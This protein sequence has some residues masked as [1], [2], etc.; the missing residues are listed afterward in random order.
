MSLETTII[1]IDPDSDR[2]GVAIYRRGKLKE[3]A[4]MTTIQ[5]LEAV[6]KEEDCLLSIENTLHSGGLYAKNQEPSRKVRDKIAIATGKCQQAQT[7]LQRWLDHHAVAY[8]LHKPGKYNWA[9]TANK[10]VFESVTGWKK[11]SNEDTRSA[12]YYGFLALN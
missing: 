11:Q 3:L 7:E 10:P 2:H 4:M 9:K 8:V 5:L 12:A 6:E 1:G